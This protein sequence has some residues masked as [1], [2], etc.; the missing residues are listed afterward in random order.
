MNYSLNKLK[1]KILKGNIKQDELGKPYIEYILDINYNNQNWRINKRFAQ[2]ANLYE[3]IKNLFKGVIQMPISSKLFI[4]VIGSLNRAFH[5]N[6]IKQLELFI[7][8]LSENE[9]IN[10]SKPFRKFFEFDKNIE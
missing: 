3:T 6:K 8:E 4:N 5:Q 1:I 7:K 2:F 10:R 9:I